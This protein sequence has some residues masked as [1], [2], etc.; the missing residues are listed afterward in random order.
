MSTTLRMLL[1]VAAVSLVIWI[2][3]RV[4]KLRV[5]MEDA[6]FWTVFAA[7]ML[8]MALFPQIVYHLCNLFGILSPANLVWMIVIGLLL[9]KVFTLAMQVSLLEE[10]VSV[11]SA[12]LALR[13]H[14]KGESGADGAV[15]EEDADESGADGAVAEE[16]A[17]ES[18]A[19][20]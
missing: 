12:E 5:K 10:K 16:D 2:L 1:I 17:G 18:G 3:H 13:S 20:A 6:I 11:L 4:R 14:R 15:A 8:L 9:E 19:Q 7:I